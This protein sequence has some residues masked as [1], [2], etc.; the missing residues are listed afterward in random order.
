VS[1]N[2]AGGG[3]VTTGRQVPF[4]MF[5]DP[6]L[7]RIGLSETEANQRGIPYRLAKLPMSSVFRAMTIPRLADSWKRLSTW[8]ATASLM[9]SRSGDRVRE[10]EMTG[11]K[12][13]PQLK[14]MLTLRIQSNSDGAA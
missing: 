11:S 6:E 7:A 13:I 4:C 8:K 2:I 10:R 3:R 5:T 9:A 12:S 1:D 14:V